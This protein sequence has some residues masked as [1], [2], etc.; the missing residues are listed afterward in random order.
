MGLVRVRIGLAD[1]NADP[2]T[3]EPPAA[4]FDHHFVHVPASVHEVEAEIERQLEYLARR[5]PSIS[6][7]YCAYVAVD[8]GCAEMA[9]PVPMQQVFAAADRALDRPVP[10]VVWVPVLLDSLTRNALVLLDL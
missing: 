7:P 2:D 9:T 10:K 1:E 4:T 8:D 6:E 3:G 5:R